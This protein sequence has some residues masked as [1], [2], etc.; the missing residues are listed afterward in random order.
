M[1]NIIMYIKMINGVIKT[2]NS[3]LLV[4]NYIGLRT[5]YQLDHQYMLQF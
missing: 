3:Y 5:I 2:K 1:I 4:N